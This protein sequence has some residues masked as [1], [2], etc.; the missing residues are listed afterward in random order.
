MRARSRTRALSSRREGGI[1]RLLAHLFASALKHPAS[2]LLRLI[3]REALAALRCDSADYWELESSEELV[4]R[5]H[6][7]GAVPHGEIRRLKINESP[8]F[9]HALRAPK[10]IVGGTK[11]FKSFFI[12]DKIRSGACL[13]VPVWPKNAPEGILAFTRNEK[14]A[15]FTARSMTQA[16]TIAVGLAVVLS[17]GSQASEANPK[18]HSARN[19]MSVAADLKPS[20]LLP[21]FVRDFT[22][23]AATML[24]ARMAFLAL[25]RGTRVETIF[26]QDGDAPAI[27]T[28]RSELDVAM[29]KIANERLEGILT[30]HVTELFGTALAGALNWTHLCLIRL[31]GREGNLLGALCLVD[32]DLR[33]TEADRNLIHAIAGHASVA[34]ENSRL[35]S[36]IEQSK[37][38]WVE[39]FDAI[40]DLIVVHDPANRI[41]RINRSLAQILGSQPSELVGVNMSVVRI[42][43]K[44]GAGVG[45]PFCSDTEMLAEGSVLNA[46]ARAYLVSTSRIGTGA[47]EGSRT[48][49]ILKDITEQRSY[50][51]QLKRERD[52]N[53]NILNHTQ[54][55]ILVLDTAG[56]ISYANHRCYEAGFREMDLL[57]RQLTQFVPR[58]RRSLLDKAFQSA[59]QGSAAENLELP[60][61]CGNRSTGQF[62]ISMSPMRDETGEVNSVVVVMTDITDARVLQ[63][64]LRH[65][66][67][68][69]ALGQLVSGVAHEINN[70]LASIIGYSDLLLENSSVPEDAKEELNIVLREAERTKE[71]VHNLLRFARQMPSRRERLD[72][73]AILRQVVQLRAYGAA[74]EGV[75]VVESPNGRVSQIFG[76]AD[77]LQQVFLNI[78]NNAYDAVRGQSRAGRIEISAADRDRFVEI[79]IRDN[80]TG[81]SDTERIFEPF[82][83]TKE[84]GK[85]TGLGL[86]ICY[87]IVREHGGEISCANNADGPG[88]TVFVRLPV[89]NET[90]SVSA[91]EAGR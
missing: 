25:C 56:L 32:R 68:M 82:Y 55:M 62:S 42:L 74:K 65:S 9:S 10:A 19:A 17:L 46:G 21:E 54:S 31:A 38:Q 81:V 67:K 11:E 24:G 58:E 34:L 79:A 66:E 36:R 51:A 14:G 15:A 13:L 49:H 8:V 2:R 16:E 30:G 73:Q 40:H 12:G 28:V 23:R 91:A 29:T 44:G 3:C 75:E 80:G 90:M 20:L 18:E 26:A 64:Q 60:F 88:C 76:D 33:V 37:R 71:I 78:L 7:G 83:T 84:V 1:E 5:H 50:Q 22:A 53:T 4:L 48:I 45:C 52:F 77:Q 72:A 85:G 86:S 35:F 69:A 47:D 57:G 89:A 6:E 43:A 27:P 61:V 63:A 39:D 87:G 41:L 70:P 59:L